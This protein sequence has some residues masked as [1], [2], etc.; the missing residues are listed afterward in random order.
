MGPRWC[1]GGCVCSE[2]KRTQL[3]VFEDPVGGPTSTLGIYIGQ[4]STR[5]SIG[6]SA[7]PLLCVFISFSNYQFGFDL[8]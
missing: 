6:P 1:A 3:A 8:V 7:W 2:T 4:F 5:T